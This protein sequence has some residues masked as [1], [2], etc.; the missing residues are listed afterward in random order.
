MGSGGHPDADAQQRRPD[1]EVRDPGDEEQETI[2]STGGER[3]A[4]AQCERERN[5]TRKNGSQ[6]TDGRGIDP[7]DGDLVGDRRPAPE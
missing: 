6:N 1:R 5:R 4:E 7:D 3:E 2:A